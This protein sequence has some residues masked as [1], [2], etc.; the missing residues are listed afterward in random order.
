MR[1]PAFLN[2]LEF[3]VGALSGL[4]LAMAAPPSPLGFLAHVA[5]VP[6][7]LF[8][9]SATR[10]RARTPIRWKTLILSF[11]LVR[12]LVEL[13][14]LLLLGDASPLTFKWALP[15]MLL[16]LGFYATVP[17]AIV[18][19][20]TA[21]L[22]RGQGAQAI[23]WFPLL[24]VVGEWMRGA[25][26][27]G[28]PWL[29]LSATQIHYLPLLQVAGVFGELGVTLL[30]VWVNVFVTL[31]ILAFRGDFPSLG[32]AVLNRWWGPVALVV[33]LS[34]SVAYGLH[35]MADARA[36][37][38]E[39]PSLRVG[40]VQANVDLRDK[41][42]IAR[43]DSTFI[44]YTR[45]TQKVASDGARLVIW[46]ETALPMDLPRHPSYLARIR[47]L[48]REQGVGLYAGFVERQ[49]GPLGR[50]DA[51]NSSFFMADDGVIQARYQ[52]MHLLPFGERMPFQELLPV[53]GKL[54]FGQ[55]E[56]QPGREHT[57]FE[58]D[59]QRFAGLICFESIFSKLGRRPVRAGAGIL[60]N[61]TN[62]GWF[63][64]TA[65]PYQHGWQSVLRAVENRVPL[66]RVANNG[67][68]FVVDP[69]GRVVERTALFE[70]DAIVADVTPNP[71]GSF[72]TRHGNTPLMLLLGGGSC[73][74]L[75][76]GLVARRQS[77]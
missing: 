25:G 60:V 75:L 50:L 67:M 28:F 5:L 31:S 29:G 12:H 61:I 16:L 6:L 72:Y 24:W 59:G 40:L 13:H 1:L 55:A 27:M 26:E 11:G 33:V 58:I 15:F 48:V 63:G 20:A 14:W 57:V 19:A 34:T 62:D 4:L 77:L 68:S 21:R 36:F 42:N 65:L 74:L 54:D 30:V 32:R 39:N 46:A 51:F 49:V 35:T 2:Q 37:A 8:L 53:L 71:G 23:W 47:D 69:A 43:R 3:R 41:W 22:R 7:L 73:F 66:L 64:R 52:K 44:P 76:V 45:L 17:D 70:R 18:I 9:F 38:E 10:W 56:W